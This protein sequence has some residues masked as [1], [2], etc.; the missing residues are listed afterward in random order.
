MNTTQD[1][2]RHWRKDSVRTNFFGSR[3][4]TLSIPGKKYP[5]CVKLR[6]LFFSN[7]CEANVLLL[8][9]LL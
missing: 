2:D 8:N 9:L 3:H 1:G 4:P 5:V 6:A 7:S